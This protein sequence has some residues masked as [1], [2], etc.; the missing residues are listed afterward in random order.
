MRLAAVYIK[1]HFLFKEQTINFGGKNIY[2]FEPNPKNPD[3]IEITKTVNPDFIDG[4]WG[5]NISLVSAIVGENGAGKS[6]ILD[7]LKNNY[8]KILILIYED[9][10]SDKIF[11]DNKTARCTFSFS[12]N[13]KENIKEDKKTNIYDELIFTDSKKIINETKVLSIIESNREVSMVC[14][15]IFLYDPTKNETAID[16]KI[17]TKR[18]QFEKK[19]NFLSDKELTDVL[20]ET[21]E[22]NIN[23]YKKIRIKPNDFDTYLNNTAR[24]LWKK[25]LPDNS[26]NNYKESSFFYRLGFRITNDTLHTIKLLILAK[27]VLFKFEM[28]INTNING[29]KNYLDFNSELEKILSTEILNQLNNFSSKIKVVLDYKPDDIE[30]NPENFEEIIKKVLTEFQN[31]YS[32]IEENQNLE[33]DITK[34]KID[35]ILEIYQSHNTFNKLIDEKSSMDFYKEF[36]IFESITPISQGEKYLIQLF[37]NLY[38][39]KDRHY[40]FIFLDEADLGFHPYWK[41]KFVNAI[42]QAIPIIFEHSKTKPIQIIFTTHDPLTLSDIPN[43]NIVYLKKDGDKTKVLKGTERPQK[44]FGANITDLLA[45]SFFIED[46]LIGDF[47][48]SKINDVIDFLNKKESKIKTKEEAKQIIEIIDEPLVKYKLKEMYLKNII[49]NDY[50]DAE[51]ERLNNL[52]T[53]SDD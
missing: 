11:Y 20:N 39:V 6:N 23:F 29:D 14:D 2:S 34:D 41:K 24:D 49:D 9:Y 3:K 40:Q 12:S 16:S 22:R 21:F 42:V 18:K 15:N 38:A 50:I 35:N 19:L 32:F 26:E 25:V 17:E 53:K 48:K 45:D 51:I 36:L 44:S 52:K 30:Y 33:Y 7:I 37:S 8:E 27:I 31:F 1:E 47:A 13:H 10:K 4:F 5:E 46:G 28:L 43:S